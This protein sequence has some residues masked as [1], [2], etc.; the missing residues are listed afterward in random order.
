MNE[1]VCF[2]MCEMNFELVPVENELSQHHWNLLIPT[3][4]CDAD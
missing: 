2:E 3:S 4:I 1:L